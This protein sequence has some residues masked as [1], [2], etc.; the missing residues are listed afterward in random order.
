LLI[1]C[2]AERVDISSG[3]VVDQDPVRWRTFWADRVRQFCLEKKNIQPNRF[4]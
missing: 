2:A 3:S 4:Q 1:F